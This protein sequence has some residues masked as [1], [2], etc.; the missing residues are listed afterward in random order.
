MVWLTLP[1]VGASTLVRSCWRRDGILT[2]NGKKSFHG[3]L[4]RQCDGLLSLAVISLSQAQ[5]YGVSTWKEDLLRLRSSQAVNEQWH[6]IRS[7]LLSCEGHVSS[8]FFRTVEPL[9]ECFVHCC[10]CAAAF[11]SSHFLHPKQYM[12]LDTVVQRSISEAA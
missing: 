2:R 4:F 6:N 11:C 7:I 9:P 1:V 8:R 5:A 12:I 3:L 10:L